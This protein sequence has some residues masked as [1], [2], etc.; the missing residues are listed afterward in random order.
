M[1][2]DVDA[3][4]T[5]TRFPEQGR[6]IVLFLI[7]DPRYAVSDATLEAVR[8][9][10]PWAA[11][12]IAIVDPRTPDAD[13]SR[14]SSASDAVVVHDKPGIDQ[15]AYVTAMRAERSEIESADEVIFTGNSWYG[16]LRSFDAVL[17]RMSADP[18]HAWQMSGN[19]DGRPETFS[20]EGFPGRPLP[21]LWLAVRREVL[22]APVWE[23]LWMGP[24]RPQHEFASAL[25]AAGFVCGEAFPAADYPRGDPA[26]FAP[27]LLVDDGCPLLSKAVFAQYP[28]FLDR[29]AV[30]GRELLELVASTGFALDAVWEDLARN[31][32]PKALNTIGGMMEVLPDDVVSYDPSRAFRIAVVAF[33][34][35]TAF[36][37]ELRERLE[38]V[39]TGFDLYVTTV[40][41]ARAREIE[42]R[43]AEWVEP[44]F[45]HFETR[46]SWTRRGHEKA[47]LFIACRDI[48]LGDRHDLIVAI[49]GRAW[50][51]KT[52]NMRYY[53][54]RYQLDNLLSSAG[55][56]ENLLG[57]F[58]K[59]KGLGLVFPPMPHVGNTLI[60][61]GWGSY[62][63]AAQRL[64][65]RL[66]IRV[67]LDRVTPLAP[68]GGMWV[69]RPAAVRAFAAER[70]TDND[71][72]RAGRKEYVEL[73][74]LQD[75]LLPV[76][77]AE[78]GFHTRTVLNSEHVAISHTSLEYK[79]DQLFSTTKGY[80]VE[81]IR[82]LHKLGF[83]GHGGTVA[84]M[85]MYLR[86]NHPRI[87]RALL[88]FYHLAFK[89]FIAV[90]DAR[91]ALRRAVR[92][93]GD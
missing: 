71:Y 27:D 60:G 9:L 49:H 6:R 56:F 53:A 69:G 88:P 73:G 20:E 75:R 76:I 91:H 38:S 35:D 63:D 50:P 21:W 55:Y 93:D 64:C 87:A 79:N 12:I 86:A 30:F 66:G 39:T 25:V 17:D 8:G 58:Q 57:L 41:G 89:A 52:D 24:P 7:D 19:I 3:P 92:G 59:E 36:V 72:G 22:D 33:V 80:P 26:L 65:A 15:M 54:R 78:Q 11:H 45:A 51:R 16:P 81:Q 14:L 1:M 34:P 28:P 42:T 70:W 48:V 90:R 74:R 13:V 43:V 61:R 77:A 84:L 23:R 62:R 46:V 82:F 68:F 83:T 85:R 31:T 40:D 18:L 2:A 32:P 5:A 10:R 37:D 29:H 67:P 44:R 4:T 47:A